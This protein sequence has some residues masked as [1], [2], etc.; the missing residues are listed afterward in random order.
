MW[1]QAVDFIDQ[2][3]R[4]HREFFR[5]S[6]SAS[7]EP[8]LWQPPVDVFENAHEVIVVVALPGVAAEAIEVQAVPGAIVVR[9]HRPMPFEGAG[10]RL[11]QLEIPYGFFE[12][13]IDLPQAPLELAGHELSHGCLVV[14]LTRIGPETR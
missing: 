11:R 8:A 10:L 3:Q 4:M 2:A 9:A 1:A 12:R 5:L 13:R 7:A 6:A 14:R